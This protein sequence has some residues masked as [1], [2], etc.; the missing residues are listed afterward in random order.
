VGDDYGKPVDVWSAGCI[1]GELINGQPMFPGENEIDQLYLIRK[2]V[3]DLTAT[4]NE[5]F[6]KNPRFVGVRFPDIKKQESL[7]LKYMGKI[8]KSALNFLKMCLNMDPNSRI[9]AV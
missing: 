3:G 9:T 8:S 5:V 2:T 4:Q 6:R 7:E 1:M